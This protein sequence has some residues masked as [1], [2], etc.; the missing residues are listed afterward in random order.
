LLAS[1]GESGVDDV[2]TRALSAAATITAKGKFSVECPVTPTPFSR[3]RARYSRLRF[4]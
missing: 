2:A 1:P 4:A 3:R